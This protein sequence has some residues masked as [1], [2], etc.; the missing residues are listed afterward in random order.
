MANKFFLFMSTDCGQTYKETK[1]ENATEFGEYVG[2][3]K[4]ELLSNRWCVEDED[5]DILL[6]CSLFDKTR[7][8]IL[9]NKASMVSR[10]MKLLKYMNMDRKK[11]E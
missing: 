5:G 10:D 8:A 7:E 3:H 4:K 1:F 11:L 2:K 9:T 6:V